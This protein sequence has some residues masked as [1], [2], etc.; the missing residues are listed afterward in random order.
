MLHGAASRPVT[1]MRGLQNQWHKIVR[2]PTGA[3]IQSLVHGTLLTALTWAC[4]IGSTQLS[5]TAWA[6]A[7]P[8]VPMHVPP[9]FLHDNPA[10]ATLTCYPAEPIAGQTIVIEITVV[11]DRRFLGDLAPAAQARTDPTGT[12][13]TSAASFYIPWLTQLDL[14]DWYLPPDQWLC[15]QQA[16]V[17][18]DSHA[19]DY[20]HVVQ[21]NR[22]AGTEILLPL[23]VAS[24]SL[25]DARIEPILVPLQAIHKNRELALS[26]AWRA[27]LSPDAGGRTLVLDPAVFDFRGYRVRT[28]ALTIHCQRCPAAPADTLFLGVGL[29]QVSS[30]V[31][32]RTIRLGESFTLELHIAGHEGLEKIAAP[33][34]PAPL[35]LWRPIW[36]RSLPGSWSWDRA[37]KRVLRW[38]I[39]PESAGVFLPP[40]VAVSYFDP[41]AMVMQTLY[42]EAEPVRVEAPVTE[43]EDL[44]K[45]LATRLAGISVRR[46]AGLARPLLPS[47][48]LTLLLLA[49]PALGP[50]AVYMLW[51]RL[52]PGARLSRAGRQARR[53]LLALRRSI[54]GASATGAPSHIPGP[55]LVTASA[56]L[57]RH[58]ADRLY[59]IAASYLCQQFALPAGEI[60]PGDVECL[61]SRISPDLVDQW[62]RYLE[63]LHRSRFAPPDQGHD[64]ALGKITLP[65]VPAKEDV[66]HATHAIQMAWELIAALEKAHAEASYDRNHQ[67]QA[68]GAV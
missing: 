66:S 40:A 52:D 54:A 28:E 31:E 65:G 45:R 20:A 21:D 44:Q 3:A 50:V 27:W 41:H 51:R 5:T 24:P 15:S 68:R 46:G 62:M 17:R 59:Q 22:A 63:L 33:S 19:G 42:V 60:V 23:R 43:S 57:D 7:T 26:L 8:P 13:G 25:A 9:L 48:E 1:N 55:S 67:Q 4:I 11:L 38:E 14:L 36:T 35:A 58:V 2:G 34:H 12:L 53:A 30:L 49:V 6:A 32:P 18:K 61:R 39:T 16:A 37:P 29:F 47:T 56:L 10:K 64:A